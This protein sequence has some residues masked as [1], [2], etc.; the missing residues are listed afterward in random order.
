M[1]ALAYP[2]PDHAVRQTRLPAAA[3][4]P[5]REAV[6]FSKHQAGIVVLKK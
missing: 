2:T 4:T 3:S 5:L 6:L 1:Q